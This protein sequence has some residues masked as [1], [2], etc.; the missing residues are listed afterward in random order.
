[1]SCCSRLRHPP[2]RS[3]FRPVA[4]APPPPAAEPASQS[5]RYLGKHPL[6]LK[7][8]ASRKLYRMGPGQ[9]VVAVDPVD[10]AALLRSGLFEPA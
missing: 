5:L 7:G 2:G 6:A 1:M 8:P 10:V 9:R 4:I 3:A